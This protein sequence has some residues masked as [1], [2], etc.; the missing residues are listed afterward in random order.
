MSTNS[1]KPEVASS[2]ERNTFQLEGARKRAAEEG[3]EVP[4]FYENFW[5]TAK[6]QDEEN[7]S[8]PAWQ[9]D[10]LEYDLRSTDWIVNKAKASDAYAQNIYAALCNNDFTKLAVIPI[11]KEQKWSCSWRHAGG[12]VADMR[13]EGD[14]IDWYCSGIADGLGNG[15]PD[16][17]L[18]YVSESVV[19]EEIKED[20][21]KLGWVVVTN[22]LVK[23]Y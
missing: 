14:Y 2:P 20:L 12:I 19:S 4:E 9:K 5:K 11:L 6:E 8:D 21:Q 16:G 1:K 10:N 23:E 7:L 13:E 17:K 18:G 15:D 3:K 22:Q